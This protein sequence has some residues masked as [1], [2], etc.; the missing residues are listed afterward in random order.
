[1]AQRLDSLE[2]DSEGER[3]VVGVD[4]HQ[5]VHVAA[6][7]T[8]LGAMLASASFPAT[9]AGYRYLITWARSWGDVLR[10]GVEGTGS[11][12]VGLFPGLSGK[13]LCPRFRDVL[14]GW[15]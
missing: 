4:T 15:G 3:V 11:Y 2:H 14:A 8:A 13:R 10:A 6:V 5:Q 9:A 1:M 12:G 7:I